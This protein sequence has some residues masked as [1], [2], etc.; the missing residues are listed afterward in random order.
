[1]IN[2]GPDEISSIIRKQIESYAKEVQSVSVGT[3]LN[4]GDGI[5][6]IHGLKD[7]MAGELL[8]FE[9]K[10]IGL[11]LNLEDANVGAVLM[12]TAIDILEGSS[13]RSTGKIA[14]VPVGETFLG[15][16]VDALA[17]P[18]DGKGDIVSSETRL[19]E[20]IAPGIITRKSVCEPVQTGITAIDSMIPIGRGQRELIIGDRQ[21][22]KT[23]V[24]I[25]TILNQKGEDVVC[26]YVAIGQRL[27]L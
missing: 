11:A 15:R 5:A 12:G 22:G 17:K 24:A 27:L 26:V 20:A 25:D 3:V 1:M 2:I 7:V 21:T 16:V 8:E 14:Q 18:L 4:I 10:T 23:S 9:D 6:R 19:V 13:V